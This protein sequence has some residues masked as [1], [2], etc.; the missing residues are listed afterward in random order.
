MMIQYKLFQN[1]PDVVNAWTLLDKDEKLDVLEIDPNQ[2][3]KLVLESLFNIFTEACYHTRRIL[4]CPCT[5]FIMMF[6]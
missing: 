4:W 6:S 1:D 2:F 5:D 3:L